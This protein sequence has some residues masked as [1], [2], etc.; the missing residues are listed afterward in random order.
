[1]L[2]L[3]KPHILCIYFRRRKRDEKEK[4]S[5]VH[6]MP[7][8]DDVVVTENEL[9]NYEGERPSFAINALFVG[10]I[11]ETPQSPGYIPQF[12]TENGEEYAQI[13]DSTRSK[14]KP[15]ERPHMST[16]KATVDDNAIGIPVDKTLPLSNEINDDTV[17]F[18]DSER[19]L[20]IALDNPGYEPTLFEVSN[21]TA[22]TNKKETSPYDYIDH[23]KLKR[24]DAEC[25]QTG[26]D[27]LTYPKTVDDEPQ[28][29][30]NGRYQKLI[31]R[32]QDPEEDADGYLRSPSARGV[33]VFPSVK[34]EH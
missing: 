16:F 23:D 26:T 9:Y 34:S 30:H 2:Q 15:K 32:D 24:D 7:Q 18:T 3:I 12:T 10:G 8:G 33:F 20:D 11:P 6:Y 22:T 21:S 4:P 17:S 14:N 28:A 19:H 1:M 25:E 31:V 27:E 13:V 5:S 29:S